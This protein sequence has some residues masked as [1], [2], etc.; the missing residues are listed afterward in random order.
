M[1]RRERDEF[2]EGG[3]VVGRLRGVDGGVE[4]M[5]IVGDFAQGVHARAEFE[6][7]RALAGA[8]SAEGRFGH[9]FGL[10]KAVAGAHAERIIDGEHGDLAVVLERQRFPL[11]I[12]MREGQ[13]E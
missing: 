5:G 8:Q 1:E 4:L 6:Y 9:L 12:R 3:A 7:L 10:I 11:D 2:G 13:G